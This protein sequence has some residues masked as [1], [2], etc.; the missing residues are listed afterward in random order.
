MIDLCQWR[1][2]IGLW[3][4]CLASSANSLVQYVQKRFVSLSNPDHSRLEEATV[5]VYDKTDNSTESDKDMLSVCQSI[6]KN[7]VTQ[8]SVQ[9]SGGGSGCI[10][11]LVVFLL[12]LLI[13]SG[14]IELNPGPKTGKT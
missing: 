8:L 7:N 6:Q 13:L 5:E 2:A 11:C 1:A 3:N 4:C 14:D 10:C 12:L 9:W